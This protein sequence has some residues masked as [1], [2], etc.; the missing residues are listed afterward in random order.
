MSL[1]HRTAKMEFPLHRA[2]TVTVGETNFFK[3]GGTL[4]ARGTRYDDPAWKTFFGADYR[5]EFSE[6]FYCWNIDDSKDGGT[7][8]FSENPP[9]L[10]EQ[11]VYNYQYVSDGDNPSDEWPRLVQRFYML[12]ADYAGGAV[13]PP[14]YQ[15]GMAV[16][17]PPA[18]TGTGWHRTGEKEITPEDA[19]ISSVFVVFDVY[20]ST[21]DEVRIRPDGLSHS[22]R[23]QSQPRHS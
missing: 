16:P 17:A 3:D 4:P 2:L 14:I 18:E 13:A 12:D 22:G 6:Y 5:K 8:L 23:N 9:T 21:T 19:R 7:L 15:K 1:T 10:E 11:A 20:Y